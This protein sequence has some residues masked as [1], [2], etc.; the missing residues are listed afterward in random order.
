[1]R[2]LRP[3]GALWRHPDFL[4]MWTGQT[5]S[6]FG[7]SI[8]QLALPIIAIRILDASAFAVAALGTVE[9]VPFLLFTLPAGVWVD[10]LRRRS[11]LI[12]GD[13][14]R[15]LLLATVPIAYFADA[16]TLGQLYVVGFLTG[17]LTVFFDVAYQSYLPALVEREHLIEGNSK[18]EVTRSAGQLAGPPVAGGLIQ[19]LTAPY[20]VVCDAVSFVVSGAFLVA[21]RK[22]EAPVEKQEDGRRPGMRKELWEGLRYVVKH[23]Y[24][25]PQA[26]ST[27][28]SNFFSSVAFSILIVFAV[29]TLHMSNGLIGVV[30]GLGSIGWLTGAMVAGPVK[31]WLGVGGAT[32]LGAALSGPATLITALT[33]VS[34]PVPFLVAG[35]ILGGWGAVVYNITQVSLRQAITP[36]RMQGRMNS[37]MRFL[38]WGPIPLGS[39]AGGAIATSFGLRT[40]LLVGA[41]GGFTSAIPIV[42]SPI[43]KLKDFPEPEEVLPTIAAG[44]GGV[45]PTVAAGVD[46]SGAVAGAGPASAL[47]DWSQFER[48][49]QRG[50]P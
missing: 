36:E 27:G 38:V 32:I 19:L 47:D 1:M 50:E 28:V 34:F 8:S 20:A 17:V 16:L 37:V 33:P 29:R 25:R 35:A 40:A 11:V 7:S 30:F 6:Q 22:A 4:K 31:R 3:T 49:E 42:L 46:E 2:S 15:A 45:A 41:I 12:V 13:V 5:I 24:L 18:L 14:G 23:P 26:I 21:I 10:R 9:F 43:R 39:L 48:S 44:E